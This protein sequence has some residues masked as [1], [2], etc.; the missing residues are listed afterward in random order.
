MKNT[1]RVPNAQASA[2][3]R[4][5]VHDFT[6]RDRWM[7]Q[8]LA[9]PALSHADCNVAC[10]LALWAHVDSGR[11][12][13]AAS[14]LAQGIG[15]AIRSVRRAFVTLEARG[16]I[17]IDHSVG[18]HNNSFRLVFPGDD[19]VASLPRT[20]GDNGDCQTVTNT[21]MSGAS[22]SPLETTLKTKERNEEKNQTLPQRDEKRNDAAG[23]LFRQT[24]TPRIPS[25]P[26]EK[27]QKAPEPAIDDAFAQFW[28]AYPLHVAKGD[29][30]IAFAK[31]IKAGAET[32]TLIDGARRYG[33]ERAA[34]EPRYTAQAG[35]WLR[36]ER[37]TD[38]PAP[39]GAAVIDQDGNPV[40]INRPPER[41]NGRSW[42]DIVAGMEAKS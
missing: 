17:V 26:K 21:P 12:N 4:P 10:R 19:N 22:L 7:R 25:A 2:N 37:W 27:K 24:E 18:G 28:A 1:P 15:S 32:N 11:C 16:W 42:V 38:E 33:A 14:T 40:P 30:R 8:V 6:S 5:H 35:R 3:S 9:D 23:D 20:N 31:A 39:N 36:A 13:P 41:R 34:Q 29:A